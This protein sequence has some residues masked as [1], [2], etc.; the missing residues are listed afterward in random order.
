M[1][2]YGCSCKASERPW[3]MNT[4]ICDFVRSYQISTPLR[5]HMPGHK[6]RPNLG[7]EGLDIT[8]I[9]GADS[10]F[11]ANGIIAQSEKNAGSLFGCRS[12]YSAE[13]SSLCIRAMLY[14]CLLYAKAQGK[15]PLIAAGRNAHKTL[16]NAAALWDI[17]IQWLYPK[18][19]SSYLS[20][21]LT[22]EQLDDYLAT[23]PLLPIAVYLTSPDYLGNMVD[24]Q[25]MSEICHRY[26][27]LL[28]V[29]NAHG[30]Y[31]KFLSVSMHPMDM[32]ADLCCD[33]AH[34]TLPALTGSAYLHISHRAPK[35]FADHAKQ[36]MSMV[37]STSPS[38]L[39]LQ[40]LDALNPYL[41]K[42]YPGLLNQFIA[43]V[44]KYKCE[45]TQY[46][47][48][49]AGNEPLKWTIAS[50][51]Y[52][53]RGDVLAQ[54]MNKRGIVCEFSDPDYLVMML[55]PEIGI[56]G[57]Q[58]LTETL[59][60]LV[61]LPPLTTPPPP[62]I[63]RPLVLS[64]RQA[65]LCLSEC[66]AVDEALGRILADPS[67]G[68]PPAVP[69]LVCGEEIDADAISAFQYYGITHCQVCIL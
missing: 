10:L 26:K 40:S 31:L 4:P 34:K 66:L 67:V 9:P 60:S 18:N 13:G 29:D 11:D 47:F 50:K 23:A 49:F 36:A 46:G 58:Y 59:K 44:Q 22:P 51:A 41:S 48:T 6:G 37:A 45:L 15:E 35:L 63:K 52:G 17:N 43:L 7:P 21:Q 57:L 32:G 1:C 16:L 53:Y 42:E 39:I 38:Y 14:L 68:C 54:L 55:T 2:H 56:E 25:R 19:S 65:S 27:V 20:C 8:E 62:A 64:P 61:K 5:L 33:S 12:F 28:L 30:A 69:I 3:E 24:V